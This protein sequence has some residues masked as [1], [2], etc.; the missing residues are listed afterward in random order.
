MSYNRAVFQ[1][2]IRMFSAAPH[3]INFTQ[4]FAEYA[5]ENN[6]KDDPKQKELVNFLDDLGNQLQIYTQ[7][8]D[9]T[10]MNVKVTDLNLEDNKAT[11][12]NVVNSQYRDQNKG[13]L[14]FF[15]G[16]L[17]QKPKNSEISEKKETPKGLYLHGGVG[18]GKTMILDLFFSQ[19]NTKGKRRVHFHEFMLDVHGKIHKWRKKNPLGTGLKKGDAEGDPIPIVATQYLIVF[20]FFD[21]LIY[22]F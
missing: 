21:L 14:D 19:L 17:S 18:L 10:Y 6:L 20:D 7:E 22:C 8:K 11:A 16:F 9:Q 2:P 3:S 12:W 13:F 15:S 4:R 5:K 1:A